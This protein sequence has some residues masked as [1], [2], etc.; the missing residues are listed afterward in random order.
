[1]NKQETRTQFAHYFLDLKASQNIEGGCVSKMDE[2]ERFIEQ[3]IDQGDVP[4]VAS[5]WKCPR[6]LK[7]E[8]LK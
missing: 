7:A 6:S 2:W 3:L 5:G 8:I 1:M 4:A